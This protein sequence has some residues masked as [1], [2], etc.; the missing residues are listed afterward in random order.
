MA[1]AQQQYIIRTEMLMYLK[2]LTV[3]IGSLLQLIA[4][5]KYRIAK[6]QLCVNVRQYR[7]FEVI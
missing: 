7:Q 5:S 1:T 2:V 4:D 3:M 6:T